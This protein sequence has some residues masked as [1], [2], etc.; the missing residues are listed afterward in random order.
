MR[1][2]NKHSWYKIFA[3]PD[4]SWPNLMSE[5]DA[6]KFSAMQRKT[7]SGYSI[8]NLLKGEVKVDELIL[9]FTSQLD[10]MINSE[11]EIC[12]DKWFTYFTFDIV[13]QVTFS[14][15]FGF[16]QQGKDIGNCISRSQGLAPYLSIMAYFHG[17]HEF[18]MSN[19]DPLITY[20]DV[21]PMKHV[22]GTTLAAVLEHEKMSSVHRH[23]MLEH[24]KSQTHSVPLTQRELL[25]A[26]N[27]NVAAGADTV[28]SEM[29]AF[30]YNLLR[31]TECLIRLREELDSA[32]ANNELSL[33]VQYREAQKLPYFQACVSLYL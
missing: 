12:L 15:P 5:L 6:H 25:A 31:N 29:Q 14:R 20:L 27:A 30:V 33:P 22:I 9:R 17:I 7:A 13:G 8:S 18:L 23:D 24:W 1:P 26:A 28:G 32:A 16:L 3:I 2:L 11:L 21:H 19:L 4:S 10:R